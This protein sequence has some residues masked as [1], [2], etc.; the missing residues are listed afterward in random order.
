MSLPTLPAA[1]PLG[2]PGA[3][4]TAAASRATTGSARGI[5]ADDG[6]G[7]FA[8]A[9]AAA[10][11]PADA[12][13]VVDDTGGADAVD[14]AGTDPDAA[15]TAD[16][17]AAGTA[18]PPAPLPWT[19]WTG[20]FGGPAG[21]D[22]G[23]G[24][25]A[26]AG[27][28]RLV[29]ALG[30]G[31]TTTRPGRD[32]AETLPAAVAAAIDDAAARDPRAL[33]LQR[34]AIGGKPAGGAEKAPPDAPGRADGDD[35]ALADD[36]AA[37]PGLAGTIDGATPS[38]KPA[39]VSRAAAHAGP[40]AQGAGPGA[41]LDAQPRD[42]VVTLPSLS[43]ADRR[44]ADPALGADARSASATALPAGSTGSTGSSFAATLASAQAGTPAGTYEARLDAALASPE[45]LPSLSAQVSTLVRNGIP[46]ARLH[47]HPAELGPITVQIEI[48]GARAQVN[49]AVE[50]AATRQVLEQGIP[51]LASALRDSGLTL[52]GGGV[53]QQPRDP[54]PQGEPRSGSSGRSERTD[55]E[56]E[57]RAAPG[58]ALPR[59]RRQLGAVDLYA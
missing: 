3:P 29:D 47:L 43:G 58:A 59:E 39:A 28:D 13:A 14:E 32:A 35:P 1:T 16:A 49:M 20:W 25:G 50:H 24:R 21:A 33:P 57:G 8:D 54:Q 34:G 51:L 15:A 23:T 18:T 5:D 6:A 11:R 52:A 19:A 2:L 17:A 38:P 7:G 42:D 45:F 27:D 10:A 36:R 31:S 30:S 37:R 12:D 4:G 26:K 56:V 48:D 22:D 46:E 41:P 40:A 53:F 9:L 44:A 55:L